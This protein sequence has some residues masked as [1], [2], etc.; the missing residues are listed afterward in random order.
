[1]LPLSCNSPLVSLFRCFY[2][3]R[4]QAVLIRTVA[5]LSIGVQAP[6]LD[7]IFAGC[8]GCDQYAGVILADRQLPCS[9]DVQN[10]LWR[11]AAG[12]RIDSQLTVLIRAPAFHSSIFEQGAGMSDAAVRIDG[13]GHI[14][15]GLEFAGLEKHR[16]TLTIQ[17]DH[18][19][20]ETIYRHFQVCPLQQV[21]TTF[22]RT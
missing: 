2:K 1:M 15:D 10:E 14:A 12:L 11:G 8:T 13:I 21:G 6:T 7:V 16:H 22:D 3:D 19:G 20:T 17:S 5:E 18:R 4:H 9:R